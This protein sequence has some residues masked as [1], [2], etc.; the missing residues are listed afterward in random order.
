MIATFGGLLLSLALPLA[1]DSA[2]EQKDDSPIGRQIDDFKLQ[3]Y[4]GAPHRLADWSDKRAVVVAFLGAECPL[5]KLYGPR[6]Q[7]LAD[8]Y[9]EQGVAF[10]GID[11][12]Q[13]DSLAEIAHYARTHKIEFALL[14]DP[15]NAVADRFGAQRTPEVFLLDDKRV[16][17]YWGRIDDQYGIGYAREKPEHA[18]LKTAIDELLAGKA[19]SRP[20]TRSLGCHIGRLSRKPPTGEIT[21]TKHI[22]GILQQHCVRCHRP[23]EIAP[24]TLLSYEDVVGWTETIREV[25]EEGRMPPW[26]ANPEFGHFSNDIRLSDEEKKLIFAWL[27]NGVPEGDAADL[28]KPIEFVEGWRIAKPDVEFAMPK[29]YTVPA[30]GVVSYQHFVIDPGFTEDKWIQQAEVRP[31]NRAVVHHLIIYFV[32]PGKGKQDPLAVLYN[33]LAAYAP[34]MPASVFR[35][36]MAKRV[37]AGSKLVIQGHY[38]PNGSEQTDLSTAGFVFADPKTVKQELRTSLAMNYEFNIPPGADEH[39]VEARH[40][41]DQDMRLYAVLPHMHLRGKSFRFDAIYPDG[42]RETLLDVPHYDFNWQNSYVFAQP[43]RMPEGTVI[44]CLAAFDNSADNLMNPDPTKA[45]R[46]GDQTW[47]EMMVGTFEAVREDQDLSLGAPK[48]V[49]TTA[50]DYEVEF[51]YRPNVEAEAVYLAGAFNDWKPDG[52]KMDGPDAEGRY[53]AK[54]T[55]KPGAHEYKFVIDGKQW[56]ADPGNPLQQGQ[57]HNSLL[58][59]P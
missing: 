23:G 49:K 31:G 53:T 26:H 55:L 4:L 28:P 22:A 7:E 24:F 39:R 52:L 32:P 50:G 51:A 14:K 56:R 11:S 18:E 46:W 58:K 37:P 40:R 59:L 48:A 16:V 20:V 15:G 45:V 9:K 38:T 34:G 41:F 10:V 19:V 47:E 43:K 33:S 2:Q 29:P 1:A 13:Q 36:G 6:L 21:Y 44:H 3:D 42:A 57:Y 17:R 25:I 8:A 27:D 54:L 30:K 12:N 35:P 5:A